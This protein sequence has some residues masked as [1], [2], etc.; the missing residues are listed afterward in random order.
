MI[1]KFSQFFESNS[2]L[3]FTD[4]PEYK[5]ILNKHRISDDIIKDYFTELLDE[6]S[7]FKS[8]CQYLKE[9]NGG[10]K[11][12]YNIQ[13]SKNIKNPHDKGFA[14]KISEKNYLKFIEMQINFIIQFNECV[15]RLKHGEDFSETNFNNINH[16]PFW[17]AGN[18]EKEFDDISQ[19]IQLVQEIET[20]DYIIAKQKFESGNNPAKNSVDD[21]IKKLKEMGVDESKSLVTAQKVMDDIMIGFMTNDDIIIVA[22]WG[23]DTGLE[24]FKNEMDDAVQAYKDGYCDEVLNEI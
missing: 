3:D 13:V 2:Y 19:I 20:D 11:L 6:G 7:E 17:G 9:T 14:W 5:Q 4:S 15:D 1:K 12:Y 22:R 23:E 8:D 21:V 16:V 18:N 10:I 24:Y